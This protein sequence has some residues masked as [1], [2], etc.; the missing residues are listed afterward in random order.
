MLGRL[1]KLV[2]AKCLEWCLGPGKCRIGPS[3]YYFGFKVFIASLL[4][5]SD[6]TLRKDIPSGDSY[7]PTPGM[8]GLFSS[9]LVVILEKNDEDPT[10]TGV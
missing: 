4:L 10:G 3:Y 2:L 6:L 1:T 7:I 9:H 5:I 8:F